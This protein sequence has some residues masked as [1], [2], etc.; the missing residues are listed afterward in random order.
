MC[1]MCMCVSETVCVCWKI[2]LPGQF[3]VTKS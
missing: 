1:V 3:V 2:V